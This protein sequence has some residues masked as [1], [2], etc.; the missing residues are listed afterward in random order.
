LLVNSHVLPANKPFVA[1]IMPD[2]NHRR[3]SKPPA[4]GMQCSFDLERWSVELDEFVREVSGE[5][6]RIQAMLP[7][8]AAT[9]CNHEESGAPAPSARP[10]PEPAPAPEYRTMPAT[11][12]DESRA[13]R[14]QSLQARLA[15]VA[16]AARAATGTM[17]PAGD[18]EP[19]HHPDRE[20]RR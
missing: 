1:P 12:P 16:E 20:A 11:R 13:A 19:G 15:I 3:T 14:L 18:D 9:P 6:G 5:L 7:D 4:A 8:S 10:A 2:S 17:R